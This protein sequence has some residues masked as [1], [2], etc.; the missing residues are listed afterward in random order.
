M[1]YKMPSALTQ[2]MA[3]K[4][5][6]AGQTVQTATPKTT[7]SSFFQT[8]KAPTKT[9]TEEQKSGVSISGYRPLPQMPQYKMPSALNQDMATKY[10]QTQTM[11][12]TTTPQTAQT[13]SFFQTTKAPAATE[14]KQSIFSTSSTDEK[15]V[16]QTYRP[17]NIPQSQFKMNSA[18]NKFYS[19][20]LSQVTTTGS[21]LPVQQ[22]QN[23]NNFYHT[24]GFTNNNYNQVEA[25]TQK[26]TSSFLQ[27]AKAPT[28]KQPQQF[29]QLVQMP[30]FK[31]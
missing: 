13:S 9:L 15:K 12:Q 11:T 6:T 20:Q 18:L 3:T 28:P 1:K 24:G 2:D 16:P 21:P 5:N 29:R 27:K 4:Y 8:T 10:T 17:L 14:N 22:N 23:T 31:M 19:N 30:N 26:T 25:T 7:S